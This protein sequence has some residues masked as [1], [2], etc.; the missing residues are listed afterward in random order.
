MKTNDSCSKTR[1]GSG[2]FRI[3]LPQGLRR[4]DEKQLLD[5]WR[6][7]P[8]SDAFTSVL[9]RKYSIR[10][11]YRIQQTPTGRVLSTYI[12]HTTDEEDMKLLAPLKAFIHRWLPVEPSET[13]TAEF[14][15]GIY[16]R[17][18]D[19]EIQ[20]AKTEFANFPRLFPTAIVLRRQQLLKVN[21]EVVE[22]HQGK[23]LTMSAQTHDPSILG[24]M[25]SALRRFALTIGGLSPRIHPDT[26]LPLEYR[27][28]V[29][30]E[31][32]Y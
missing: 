6:D 25:S 5:A 28:D 32:P 2:E 1:F 16:S 19:N 15:L 17:A 10:H 11:Q 27:P 4:R 20:K 14:Q 30:P 3:Q 23:V 26:N 9:P 12:D 22:T 18:S 24:G 8:T 31:K 21:P 7:L 13:P 29:N